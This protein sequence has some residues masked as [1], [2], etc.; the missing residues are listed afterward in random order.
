MILLKTK[1]NDKGKKKKKIRILL[2]F[3]PHSYS[4][5]ARLKL[6]FSAFARLILYI[7]FLVFHK[8]N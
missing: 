7:N 5:V 4:W 3:H 2:P 8:I 1:Y 6:G